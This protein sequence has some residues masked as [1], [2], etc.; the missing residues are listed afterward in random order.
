M[1][2]CPRCQNEFLPGLV[3]CPD[4]HVD[5]IDDHPVP[6]PEDYREEDWVELYTFPG[7]LYA[8]MAVELL[9]REGIPSYSQSSL[10]ADFGSSYDYDTSACAVYVLEA[11][12]ERAREVIETMIDEL[13]SGLDYEIEE[14]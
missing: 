5:L 1:P 6:L 10:S 7:S 11:D 14:E 3:V 8:R 2:Y 9:Q 4:C 12:Y 13:P